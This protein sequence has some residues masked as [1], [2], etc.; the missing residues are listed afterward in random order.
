MDRTVAGIA[1]L[2]LALFLIGCASPETKRPFGFAR[3]SPF[4]SDGSSGTTLAN[5]PEPAP[6]SPPKPLDWKDKLKKLKGRDRE[7]E[8]PRL[9]IQASFFH[10]WPDRFRHH[11]VVLKRGTTVLSAEKGLALLRKLQADPLVAAYGSPQ[12]ATFS[13]QPASITIG[14]QK[15]YV[16]GYSAQGSAQRCLFEPLVGR[17]DTGLAV[18]TEAALEEGKIVFKK[19][20]A[21]T[22]ELLGIR[23]CTADVTTGL[24]SWEKLSWQEPLLYLGRGSLSAGVEGV[25]VTPGEILLIPLEYSV[26]Q[27]PSTTR[28]LAKG[29]EVEEVYE[30]RF[31]SKEL[32]PLNLQTV[33]V[34]RAEILP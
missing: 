11:G 4:P 27:E 21:K 25:E 13:G 30:N 23:T 17:Y 19:I 28:A 6:S 12:L 2:F 1:Y 20:L 34:V 31:G 9:L 29:G 32:S 26:H 16:K 3:L 14:G 5:P 24:F 15:A 8:P 10:S 18:D 33:V 22:A 7:E